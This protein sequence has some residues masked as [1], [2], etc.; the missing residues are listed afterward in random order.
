MKNNL[1]KPTVDHLSESILHLV[2][3]AVLVEIAAEHLGSQSLQHHAEREQ[4][5]TAS[6]AQQGLVKL[7]HSFIG[8]VG[9][10]LEHGRQ[11]DS[12]QPDPNRPLKPDLHRGV[13]D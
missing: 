13:Q 11:Q 2:K 3:E 8:C 5:G 4:H 9:V 7:V 6:D 10:G 1:S 12:D